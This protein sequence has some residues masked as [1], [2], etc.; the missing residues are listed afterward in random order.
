MYCDGED[1]FK[2]E[3]SAMEAGGRKVRSC[4]SE[5]AAHVLADTHRNANRMSLPHLHV[6]Y[7]GEIGR[8]HIQEGGLLLR[9]VR[10]GQGLQQVA[11]VVAG[12]EGEPLHVLVQ[13]QPRHHQ[14]LAE[15]VH[16]DAVLLEPVEVDSRR[17]QQLNAILSEHVIT[18][19]KWGSTDN[20]NC[21]PHSTKKG[22]RAVETYERENL[23]LNCQHVQP[24]TQFPS[25]SVKDNPNWMSF[26][27]S[28]L[29]RR[30]CR[31]NNSVRKPKYQR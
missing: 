31:R 9:E 18:G 20:R 1:I 19:M 2:G 17:L 30:V 25:A 3:R 29:H 11:E 21:Q 26:N 16:V 5:V 13:H 15:V 7:A 4:G 10:A 23:K 12:V 22:S 6:V 27:I 24:S 28:T 14:A 8:Q